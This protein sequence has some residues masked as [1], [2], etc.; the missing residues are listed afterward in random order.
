MKP[1]WPRANPRKCG[2]IDR[3]ICAPL[4]G[5]H[6]P[7]VRRIQRPRST[8]QWPFQQIGSWG[9]GFCVFGFRCRRYG[10]IGRFAPLVASA[11]AANGHPASAPRAVYFNAFLGIRRT[12]RLESAIG[13]EQRTQRDLIDADQEQHHEANHDGNLRSARTPSLQPLPNFKKANA[14]PPS[15]TP[16]FPSQRKQ[17]PAVRAPSLRPHVPRRPKPSTPQVSAIA[18]LLRP[19]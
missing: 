8:T 14:P 12:R 1:A 9:S 13:S 17:I 16:P 19:N 5:F 3:A 2:S 4:S 7:R 10:I 18:P 6:F 11:N 15:G